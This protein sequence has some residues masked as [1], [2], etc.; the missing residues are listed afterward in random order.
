MAYDCG[1]TERAYLSHT[2]L[3]CQHPTLPEALLLLLHP[4]KT[5]LLE[6]QELELETGRRGDLDGLD[7][8]DI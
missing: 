6:R 1:L 4:V 8:L 2:H 7:R 3:V 5:L